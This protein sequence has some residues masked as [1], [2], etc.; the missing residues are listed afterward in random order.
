VRRFRTNFRSRRRF[1]APGR[2]PGGRK[3]VWINKTFS[4]IGTQVLGTFEFADLFELVAAED[5]TDPTSTT[6]KIEYATVVRS[7]GQVQCDLIVEAP[8]ANG[9]LWSA[10]VFVRS[11][12]AVLAE[13]SAAPTG[14]LFFI[15]PESPSTTAQ[16]EHIA[17]LQPLHW[18]PWRSYSAAFRPNADPAGCSEFFS[19]INLPSEATPYKWDITQRRR[20]RTDESLWLLVSGVFICLVGGEN[21]PVVNTVMSRTLIHDD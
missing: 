10:A 20:M 1:S 5:Y 21:S 2:A 8:G 6:Q 9:I 16:S 4:A 11:Q 12:T 13:F 17:R 18:Q 7:V 19:D 14:Q 3:K 15:H